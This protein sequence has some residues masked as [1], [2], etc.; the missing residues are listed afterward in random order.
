MSKNENRSAGRKALK[1]WGKYEILVA[2]L[3]AIAILL[4]M[5]YFQGLYFLAIIV[6]AM[7]LSIVFERMIRYLRHRNY[8]DER[9][10][11]I[12]AFAA[13]NSFIASGIVLTVLN[14][15]NTFRVLPDY[16]ISYVLTLTTFVM[17]AVFIAWLAYYSIRGDVE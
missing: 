15:L 5:F 3:I 6:A 16:S 11:K 4:I 10:V 13:F 8:D 7:G 12:A 2:L 9:M 1:L 17:F 14:L